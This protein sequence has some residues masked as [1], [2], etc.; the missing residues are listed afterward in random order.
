MENCKT[1]FTQAL[2]D[3][4]ITVLPSNKQ[5]LE[6]FYQAHD[7]SRVTAAGQMLAT[8]PVGALKSA[9]QRK[10]GSAPAIY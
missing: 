6:E 9:I 10:Y 7:V 5:L 1:T 2:I 8:F 4:L 3:E